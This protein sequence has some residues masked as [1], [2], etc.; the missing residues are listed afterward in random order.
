MDLNMIL[1]TIGTIATIETRLREAVSQ[2]KQNE[3]VK[4]IENIDVEIKL[5][6]LKGNNEYLKEHLDEY[7]TKHARSFKSVNLSQVFST[8]EKEKYV[9]AFFENNNDLIIYRDTIT[10]ILYDYIN[11]IEKYISKSLTEGEKF[12]VKKV[13]QLS[14]QVSNVNL[15]ISNY[16]KFVETVNNNID[17]I[18]EEIFNSNV[19]KAPKYSESIVGLLNMIFVIIEQNTGEKLL[20][21]YLQADALQAENLENVVFKIQKVLSQIAKDKIENVTKQKF[22][23]GLHALHFYIQYIATDFANR[24]N[25]LFSERMQLI[26]DCIYCYED[27]DPK[28]YLALGAMGLRNNHTDE[29]IYSYIMIS[30][31]DYLSLLLEVLENKWK[32]RDY[33]VLEDVAVQEMQKRLWYQIQSSITESNREWII[34]IVNHDNITDVELAQMFNVLVG[35][36]RKGLYSATKTFLKHKYVD[37]YTTSLIIYDDYKKV[38]KNKLGI[39]V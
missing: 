29:N 21:K 20:K 26:I 24:I 17:S 2:Y 6:R 34:K 4:R 28:Y 37:D 39:G 36:L 32:D 5:N 23:N 27:K 10:N 35:D 8:D 11:E 3:M 13:N 12:I 22:D 7:I 31:A 15:E 25:L 38:I 18:K 16:A 33:K 30:L 14:E 1:S 9:R 19:Y